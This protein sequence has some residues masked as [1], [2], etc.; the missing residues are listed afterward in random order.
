MYIMKTKTNAD[1]EV[2]YLLSRRLSS[3]TDNRLTLKK[4]MGKLLGLLR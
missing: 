4:T 1:E 3:E 2:W